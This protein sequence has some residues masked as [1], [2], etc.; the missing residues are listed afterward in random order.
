MLL[1]IGCILVFIRIADENVLEKNYA[2]DTKVAAYV[3]EH[4]SPGL[5]KAAE[6]ISFFGS[7]QFLLPAYTLLILFLLWKKKKIYALDT[8]IIYISSRAVM[9]ILKAIFQRQRPS[10][11]GKLIDAYSFPSGHA[12]SSLIFCCIL[13]YFTWK[14]R[15]KLYWKI[16]VAIILVLFSLAIGISRLVLNVHYTTDVIAGLCLAIIWFLLSVFVME[17]IRKKVPASTQ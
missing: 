9:L 5:I 12:V 1:F 4:N 2:L 8:A 14:L 16:I 11:Y 3:S 13:I 15:W 6:F 7:Q 10:V 17:K